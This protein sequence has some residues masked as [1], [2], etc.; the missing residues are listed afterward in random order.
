MS[1]APA[2]F[3]RDTRAA[4]KII[5]VDLG[6][7]GDSVHLI[8][9]LVE[10]RRHYPQAE[11]HTI[12]ATVGA[13][14]LRLVPAV[15][16]AWAFPLT[17]PSPPW[18]RHWGL[19]RALR[20][21]QFDTAFNFSGGDRAMFVTAVTG[22]RWRVAHAA[23]RD[24]FWSK[25][26]IPLWVPRQPQSIPVFQ[27]RLQV[28][29]GCGLEVGAPSW[30]LE[31]PA[32]AR[33]YAES[34]NLAS[35]VHFSINASSPLKEWPLEHW[36]SLAR[37]MLEAVPALRLVASGSKSGR[38]QERLTAMAAK[39]NDKRLT[40]LAGD[41]GIAELGA[42]LQRCRLHIGGDSGV[43][44]LAMALGVPTIAL[45]RDYPAKNEWLPRGP[46]HRHLVVPCQ[47][48]D[49]RPPPCATG[50]ARCLAALAPQQVF[51][52]ASLV[53]PMN[54]LRDS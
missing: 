13:E 46:T 22:A 50:P 6:F 23:G 27:Q 9:A 14:V 11:L 32:P 43:L 44:H 20:R 30:D 12:S 54:P 42:V 10:L 7:L 36:I 25:W 40:V 41:C 4:R 53:Q 45:F 39:L 26:L 15:T 51:A 48:V 47:C 16:R 38:E 2:T 1:N 28:L 31:I 5:V 49:A 37:K 18:W 35:A 21:E 52:A 34:L 29:A 33:R 3:Y 17:A 19:L 8:P 24:H